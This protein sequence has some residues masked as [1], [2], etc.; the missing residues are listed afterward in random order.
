MSNI[1]LCITSALLSLACIASQ[2]EDWGKLF[3]NVT[4]ENR[5]T[6]D[7]ARTAAFN[8]VIPRLLAEDAGALRT[9]LKAIV[10]QFDR[11][12]KIR[13]QASAIFF[14]VAFGR[15][16]GAV[17]L[18]EWFPLL[19]TQLADGNLRIRYNAA[20]SLSSLQPSILDKLA[21]PLMKSVG[22]ADVRVATAAVL[23]VARLAPTNDDS[24]KLIDRV[25]KTERRPELRAAALN[26]IGRYRLGSSRHS[27][28]VLD[29]LADNDSG[30]VKEALT[31]LGTF[32]S[33]VIA[34]ATAILQEI[35]QKTA[36]ADV[37]E[38]ATGLLK[39]AEH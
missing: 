30:V 16:D 24:A 39:R 33:A 12:E 31:T 11:E 3:D 10:P 37:R 1:R 20:F 36:A 28:A 34:Q 13:I 2:P 17:V 32:D 6:S 21:T 19:V 8:I 18:A 22:D 26:A 38:L 23:G 14:T 4:S 7:S 5:E 25:A 9:D 35:V 15:K 27:T 29:A